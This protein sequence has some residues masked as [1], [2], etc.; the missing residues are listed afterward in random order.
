MEGKLIVRKSLFPISSSP[1]L[2][3]PYGCHLVTYPLEVLR[4]HMAVDPGFRATSKIAS[5]ML[6]EEGITS[7]TTVVLDRL[8]SAELLTLPVLASVMFY[9]LDTENERCTLQDSV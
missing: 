3:D 5:S 4:L 6:R 1:N 9:P 2:K 7:F 8:F